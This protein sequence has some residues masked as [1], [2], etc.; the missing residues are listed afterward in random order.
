[1]STA[2]SGVHGSDH[3]AHG[4]DDHPVHLQHHFD[5]SSQQ[6]AAAKLGMWVFLGTEILMFSGLFLAYFVLRGMYPEMVLHAHEQL[7]KEL[8]AVNTVVLILSSLTMA[9]AVRSAQTNN[10]ERT[11]QLLLVTLLCAGTFMVIKYIEYSAK[12]EHG[13][14]PGSFYA[15]H[16]SYN[17]ERGVEVVQKGWYG[18]DQLFFG[19]YFVMT[20]LH[21]VHVLVG[22]GLIIWMMKMNHDGRLHSGYFTPIE[23]VGLYWHLV[24]LVWIFL[25]PLLYLVK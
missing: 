9:L 15:E 14:L 3:G 19:I 22:M 17:L 13:T 10:K 4:H 11:N 24:D 18:G 12:F 5:N 2:D 16:I 23:N 1:M 25:F 21:G 6:E 7:N 20:G 8:G